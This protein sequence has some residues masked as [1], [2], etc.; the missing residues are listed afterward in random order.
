MN[1][2]VNSGRLIMPESKY[3]IVGKHS[4]HQKR[5]LQFASF[6]AIFE[7][8]NNTILNKIYKRVIIAFKPSIG[9]DSFAYD[10]LHTHRRIGAAA[11]CLALVS[12]SF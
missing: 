3:W 7:K 4:L 12:G 10:S 11:S 5:R 8:E 9:V 2:A 6:I 1:L